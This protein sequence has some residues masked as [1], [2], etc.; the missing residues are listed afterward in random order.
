VSSRKLTMINKGTSAPGHFDGHADA[1]GQ[2]HTHCQMQHVQGYTGS[3]WMP[4]LD[5]YLLRMAPA[6]ARVSA[7]K[8]TV[9][10]FTNFAGHFDGHGG[11]PVGYCAHHPSLWLSKKPPNAA[12]RQVFTQITYIGR[13]IASFLWYFSSSNC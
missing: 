9:K 1:W 5:D 2:C 12:I 8:T 13:T 11:A 6:A 4:P 10:K 7:N 3:H